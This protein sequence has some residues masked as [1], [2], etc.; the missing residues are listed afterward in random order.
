M[1]SVEGPCEILKPLS[2][3]LRKLSSVGLA[4]DFED[5]VIRNRRKA[6]CVAIVVIF[7]LASLLLLCFERIW[8][9]NEEDWLSYFFIY[10]FCRLGKEANTLSHPEGYLL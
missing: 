8:L 5:E 10:L 2:W 9:D 6:P 4:M 7:F 1:T 3:E